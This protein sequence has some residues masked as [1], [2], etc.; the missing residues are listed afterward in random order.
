M[1]MP[2]I[3]ALIKQL[4]FNGLSNETNWNFFGG[5]QM[6]KSG[7]KVA[8]NYGDKLN[9]FKN[10][11]KAEEYFFTYKDRTLDKL[12]SICSNNDFFSADYSIDSLSKLEKWYFDL[13][14]KKEFAK[15][16]IT[17]EELEKIMEI[18]FGE[19]VIRNN[20]KARWIVREYPFVK[21]KYELLV[22]NELMSMTIIGK[23]NNL[24]SRQGNKRKKLMFREYNK[25]FNR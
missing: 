8:I 5:N 1:K 9:D 10:V 21:G 22:N 13:Y 15:I 20:V 11:S 25:Y 16:G 6:S 23:F 2:V 4:L 24:C 18:Y 3:T 14:E 7:L 17:Q 19:V 12:E